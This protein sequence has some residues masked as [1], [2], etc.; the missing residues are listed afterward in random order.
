MKALVVGGV[1]GVAS[2][3]ILA[4][5]NIAAGD[6]TLVTHASLWG[7]F[8]GLTIGGMADL[9][10]DDLLT[11]TLVGGNVGLIAAIPGARA[12]K[13]ARGQIWV[14][15]AIGLAGGVAGLGLDLITLPEDDTTA[16]LIPTL[17]A[18]VGLVIGAALTANTKWKDESSMEPWG[19][20][21]LALNGGADLGFPL[22]RP[23][24]ITTLDAKARRKLVPSWEVRLVQARFGTAPAAGRGS[25]L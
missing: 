14:I 4:N 8:Y 17:G 10:D 1:V 11:A 12:W 6:A 25:G 2:G 24:T 23:G 9:D 21:L 13:P 15:S 3:L 19:D 18:T 7:T 16:I 22:P 20:S 5:Q